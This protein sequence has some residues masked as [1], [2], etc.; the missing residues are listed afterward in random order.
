MSKP[1]VSAPEPEVQVVEEQEY[2]ISFE[3]LRCN[4]ATAIDTF[5]FYEFIGRQ[6]LMILRGTGE[7]EV[8]KT[9]AKCIELINMNIDLIY[10]NSV[11]F[12]DE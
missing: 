11:I 2:S 4:I 9:M 10:Q 1:E 12:E 6:H 3:D 8:E 5:N 7:E